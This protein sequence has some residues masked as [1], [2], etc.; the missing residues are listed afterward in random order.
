MSDEVWVADASGKLI[1]V[2]PAVTK[3]FDL[4][5][6]PDGIEFGKAASGFEVLRPDGSERPAAEAPP[7]RALKGEV[8]ID[9]EEI[10]KIPASGKFQHAR[11]NAAPIKDVDGHILGS[12]SV[13]RDITERK[14]MEDELRRSNHELQQ[15]AYLPPTT[16]R[17]RCA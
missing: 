2:N 11:V 1:M 8:V 17:N 4:K 16:C 7:S 12:V 5:V 10:V 13:V 9:Q 3:T 14:R 15:F 6:G